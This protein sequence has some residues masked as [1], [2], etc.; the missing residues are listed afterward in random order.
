M[1]QSFSRPA[2]LAGLQTYGLLMA[3]LLLLCLPT[4]LELNK[5]LWQGDEQ[6]SGPF[7]FAIILWLFYQARNNAVALVHQPANLSGGILFTLGLVFYILGRSQEIWLFEVSAF[8][9]LLAG[10]L[11]MVSGKTALKKYGFAILFIIFL[12]PLPSFIIDALTGGLKTQVSHWAEVILYAADY[13]VARSGV[14]LVVGQYQLL[15]A[16][17]C[18]GMNSMFSLFALGLLYIHTGGYGLSWRGVLLFL[19]VIPIAFI[20]NVIRVI[21]LILVTYHFGDAAGQGFIHSFAGM[22]VFAIALI[23]FFFA[24]FIFGMFLFKQGKKR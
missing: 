21:I 10:I 20:A 19:C 13:P 8:I 22:A 5:T 1:A 11:L 9:P 12:V 18:S 23:A 4:L 24:D 6:G 15:V 7:I 16:D 2:L 14:M 3:G 17:A